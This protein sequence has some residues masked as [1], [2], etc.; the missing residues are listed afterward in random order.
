VTAGAPGGQRWPRAKRL[1][2]GAEIR[3]VLRRGK[4]SGTA[5]VD[6]FDSA[7]LLSYPRVGVIV[8]RYG[9]SAVAR[10]RVKRRLREIT[11]RALLPWLEQAG[12]GSD[13][14]LRARRSA[15]E[16]PYEALRVGLVELAER[17]W[18]RG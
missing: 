14:I 16:A 17:R 10:N 6:V 18:A 4:R 15:Y 2:S 11:R 3:E 8:P 9:H 12:V 1:T 13:I 7:S 5:H